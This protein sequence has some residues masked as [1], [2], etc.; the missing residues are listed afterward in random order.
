MFKQLKTQIRISGIFKGFSEGR[1]VGLANPI[2]VIG[3]DEMTLEEPMPFDALM[4]SCTSIISWNRS[5]AA[6][7]VYGAKS[8][9]D[10]LGPGNIEG[11]VIYRIFN[12]QFKLIGEVEQRFNALI[13]EDSEGY[14]GIGGTVV[15]GSC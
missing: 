12:E 15:E 4:V 13:K 6:P 8:L 5:L 10:I 1:Y 3:E 14:V 7:A 9:I 2:G 11:S